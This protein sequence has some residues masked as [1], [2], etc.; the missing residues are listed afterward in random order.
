MNEVS[1][2]AFFVRLVQCGSLTATAQELGVTP[3]AVSRRLA[4]LERRLGVRLLNRTTRSLGATPEGERYLEQARRI[5]DDIGELERELA[6]SRSEPQ[7]LLRVNTSFG[8]GRR[9]IAPLVSDFVRRHPKVEI[10]LQLT[11][12]IPPLT[13]AAFDVSI[14]FGRPPDSRLYARRLLTNH[15]VLCAAPAYLDAHAPIATP[16]DLARH[17]CIVIRENEAAYGSWQLFAADDDKR[18]ETVK[19][20]GALSSNDGETAVKWALAGHGVLLR[21]LWDIAG[22]LAAGRLRRVL[23][24]WQSAPADVYALYPERMHLSAKVRAFVDF[25]GERIPA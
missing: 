14:R 11:D 10:Q 4:A 18:R 22:E 21:S 23:P 16:K 17:A 13:D 1:D 2:L 20:G 7:G 12:R 15:R 24:G 19:V 8:F 6:G 9:L 5:L 25:L 3:P